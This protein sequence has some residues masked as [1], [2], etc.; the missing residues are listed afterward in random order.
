MM[1]FL[2]RNM[3]SFLNK[4]VAV[5]DGTVYFHIIPIWCLLPSPNAFRRFIKSSVMLIPHRKGRIHFVADHLTK[6]LRLTC[7]FY[8]SSYISLHI[9]STVFLFS[10]SNSIL[11][12]QYVT[13]DTLPCLEPPFGNSWELVKRPL[14]SFKY[15][16]WSSQSNSLFRSTRSL[17]WVYCWT[18]LFSRW[19]LL[20][21]HE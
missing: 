7:A 16:L 6:P 12:V 15:L 14:F 5:S 19:F 10:P 13:W 18:L 2:D 21:V 4:T 17:P 9:I 3:L 8:L 1:V 20:I 11:I